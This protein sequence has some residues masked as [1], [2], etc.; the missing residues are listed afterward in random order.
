MT[1]SISSS[2]YW[3]NKSKLSRIVQLLNNVGT[4]G[5]TD[6]LRRKVCNPIFDISTLSIKIFPFPSVS[7]RRNKVCINV[8]FPLPLRPTIPTRVPASISI[9]TLCNA[10]GNVERY[11]TDTSWSWIF[12]SLGQP[13]ASSASSPSMTNGASDS[14][15]PNAKT[16]ST[17]TIWL[18]TSADC[19]THHWNNPASCNSMLS[20]SPNTAGS[21]LNQPWSWNNTDR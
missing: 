2:V 12:P 1:F 9:F 3:C 10:N 4:W 19:R 21:T 15:F 8:L 7:N 6:I 20:D 17:L 5:I 16:R 18:T 13:L 14:T 11:R